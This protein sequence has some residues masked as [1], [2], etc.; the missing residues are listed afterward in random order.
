MLLRQDLRFLFDYDV[1]RCFVE[2]IL[3]CPWFV[4]GYPFSEFRLVPERLSERVNGHLVAY[5]AWTLS[6]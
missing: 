3:D 6:A 2:S 1:V 5:P 4:E